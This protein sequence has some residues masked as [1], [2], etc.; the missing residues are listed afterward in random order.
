MIVRRLKHGSQ[1]LCLVAYESVCLAQCCITDESSVV[2]SRLLCLWAPGPGR[3]IPGKKW[4]HVAAPLNEREAPVAELVLA[5]GGGWLAVTS[6]QVP[7]LS[8]VCSLEGLSNWMAL[9]PR[10]WGDTSRVTACQHVY[11]GASYRLVPEGSS[12]TDKTES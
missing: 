5:S 7:L 1:F 8:R 11:P 4:I 9:R 6:E 2:A 3:T 12:N 10:V